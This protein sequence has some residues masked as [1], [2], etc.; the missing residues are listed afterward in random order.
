M[1]T[2]STNISTMCNSNFNGNIL[3]ENTSNKDNKNKSP[4][5]GNINN[6]ST[7]NNLIVNM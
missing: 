3:I 5:N 7:S 2:M 4:I 6:Y 1:V